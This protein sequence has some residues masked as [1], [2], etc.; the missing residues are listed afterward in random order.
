METKVTLQLVHYSWFGD[1]SLPSRNSQFISEERKDSSLVV[2]PQESRRMVSRGIRKLRTTLWCWERPGKG[3]TDLE[4]SGTAMSPLQY[5]MHHIIINSG[6]AIR[7]SGKKRE[8]VHGAKG[9]PPM[10]KAPSR[11]KQ[12]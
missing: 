1:T 2:V 4:S 5:C 11:T 12:L 8:K 6:R 3:R 10:S 9:C 7:V